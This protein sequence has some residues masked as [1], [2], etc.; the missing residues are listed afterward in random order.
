MT[1]E[2]A[3]RKLTAILSADVKGYSRLMEEDELATVR[4]LEAY[5]EMIAEVIRNYSGRVVDSPGDNLLAEFSSVVDAVESAIEIQKELKAKNE[6]LPENRR[7][8]F[9]IGIN[10]GDVI[11]EGERIYGD[12][13]NIAARIEGLAAGG[14]ICISGTVF[15]HVEGKLELDFEY[16]GEQS[17]KNI[18][19]PVRVYRAKTASRVSDFVIGREL[20]LPDKPSIAV[21]PFVNMS[22]DPTQE[23]IGDG[24]SENIISTLSISSKMFVIARNSTFSYKGKVIKVQQVAEEMGVQYVL[25]GSIQKSGDRVRITA[26]L[27]DALSGHHLWSDKYDR[28]LIELFDLQDEITKKIVTSLQVKLTHGEAARWAERTTENF[29]AWSYFVRGREL[30]MKFG[31]EDNAKAR[32]LLEAATELDPDYAYAWGVLGGTHLMDAWRGW[33]ESPS[34][35]MK[36]GRDYVQKS[37]E[38]DGKSPVGHG[39]LG[40]LYLMQGEHEKALAEHK[41]TLSFHPNHD[42]A[43]FDLGATMCFSGRFEESIELIEKA[44]RLSPYYPAIYLY[45][46]GINYVSLK[47]F[48]EAIEIFTQLN[49]RCQK[50]DL[51]TWYAYRGLAECYWELGRKEEARGYLAKLLKANPK[52]SLESLK[53]D[54]FPFKDPGLVQPRIEIFRKLGAPERPNL[55]LPDKPSI[56]VLPFVN[57]SDDPKQDYFCDGITEEIITGLSAIRKLFVIAR[58]STFTYKGKAVKVQE[59]GRELGVRYVLEGSVRKAG[60]RVRITAQ[61]VDATTGNHLWAERYNR[62]LKDIFAI[63]DEITMKIITAM[64]V[65]L[66]E[67]DKAYLLRPKGTDNIEAYLKL[68]EGFHHFNRFSRDGTQLAGQIFEEVIT[69]D[70]EYVAPYY[71]LGFVHTRSISGGWSKN[72]A[73]SL[74]QAFKLAQ[75]ALPLDESHPGPLQ[76]LGLVSLMKKQFDK[77]ISLYKRALELSPNHGPGHYLL[78]MALNYAGE[79][80][81]AIPYCEEGLRLDPLSPTYCLWGL[82]MAY[83]LTGRYEEAISSLKEALHHSPRA[84]WAYLELAACSAALERQEEACAAVSEIMRLNPEFSV[85]AYVKTQPYKNPDHAKHFSDL[86][87]KAGLK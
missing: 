34:N 63:Q 85:E 61:L 7:M 17:V 19:K 70:P 73:K 28:K 14:G 52:W 48:E 41:K 72:P 35:S 25:E 46:L 18:K 69:L 86:L 1:E 13:V 56:A 5:R 30:Y 6:D 84:F 54:P 65:K 81:K 37:L 64:Q 4:T 33:S 45:S 22:G 62:E 49:E 31:K 12:G 51:P 20:T 16:L 68:L 26:Q 60:D 55:P 23:Y 42:M 77:A 76:L 57:M 75:K 74:D 83:R 50:G 71:F 40:H 11:E 38:L 24:F 29:E 87:R 9:R 43:H 82:A 58:N 32:E 10:L 36:L 78:G 21:L 67:G 66:T 8:L 80:K 44:M 3:K 79:P 2:R 15:D 27:I 59:V 39:L 47:R 53:M